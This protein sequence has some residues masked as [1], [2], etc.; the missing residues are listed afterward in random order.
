MI[1]SRAGAVIVLVIAALAC[2]SSAATEPEV[3]PLSGGVPIPASVVGT[4]SVSMSLVPSLMIT[5]QAGTVD[6]VLGVASTGCMIVEA[7]ADRV[8]D[9]LQVHVSRRGDPA[10]NCVPGS[11]GYLYLVRATD[12]PP[13]RYEIRVLD[14]VLG[15]PV[16]EAGRAQMV[17]PG[18]VAASHS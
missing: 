17:V 12:V 4:E 16:R 5:A 8:G 18:V 15:M 6:V 14:E 10:A 11:F 1:S 7:S 9:V 13:G 2:R 3:V